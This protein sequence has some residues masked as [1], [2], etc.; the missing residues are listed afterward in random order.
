MSVELANESSAQHVRNAAGLALK[1]ALT[2]RVCYVISLH[3]RIHGSSSVTRPSGERASNRVCKSMAVVG[4]C[5]KGQDQKGIP[6]HP[7]LAQHQSRRCCCTSRRCHCRRRASP[8]PMARLNWPTLGICE[9]P[10]IFAR[11][12]N[13]HAS[14]DRIYLRINCTSLLF[15][16][17]HVP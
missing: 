2:A 10:S 13:S 9:Q 8:R 14:S 3:L 11:P 12:E 4:C 7:R 6:C 17:A 15:F 1:N 16:C 5:Y